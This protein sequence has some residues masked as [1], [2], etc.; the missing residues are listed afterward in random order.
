MLRSET[1]YDG[2]IHIMDHLHAYVPMISSQTDGE[3]CF[4][5]TIYILYHCLTCYIISET[6]TQGSSG[7]ITHNHAQDEVRAYIYCMHLQL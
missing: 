7:N 2:M 6:V 4:L 3:S 5:I 1:S